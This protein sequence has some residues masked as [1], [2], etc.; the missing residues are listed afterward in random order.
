MHILYDTNVLVTIISR[1]DAI[2]ALKKQINEGNTIHVSSQHILSEVE[3]VLVERM[4][5]TKQRAKTAT[6]LLSRQS[7][8]V[9]PENIEKICRDPFDDYILAAAVLGK[10]DYIITHDKDLLVLRTHKGIG[11]VTLVEFK[12]KV[13]KDHQ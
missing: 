12:P 11:I 6:R 2:I 9:N 10:V 8:I 7:T 3:A 5:L 4:K 13:I 1:R